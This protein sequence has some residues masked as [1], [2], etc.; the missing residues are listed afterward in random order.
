MS[1]NKITTDRILENIYGVTASGTLTNNF[2]GGKLH[3]VQQYQSNFRNR[4]DI[5]NNMNNI[6]YIGQNVVQKQITGGV[7]RRKNIRRKANE[8]SKDNVVI[9]ASPEYVKD[10]SLQIFMDKFFLYYRMS[11]SP[12]SAIYIIP[13]D[14]TLKSMISKRGDGKEGSIELQSSVRQ[15]KE[16]QW[17]KYFFITFGDNSKSDRYRI[18]PGLTDISAYPNKSFDE[19][20][21]TNLLGEVFYISYKDKDTV[22]INSKPNQHD[23]NQL[24][25]IARFNNGG[26]IFKGDIPK[27]SIEK[28]GPKSPTKKLSR[29]SRQRFDDLSFGDIPFVGGNNKT[30]FDVLQKYDEAYNFD[31][32]LASEHFIR[33]VANKI[34]DKK[35]FSNSDML[36]NSLYYCATNPQGVNMSD[37]GKEMNE[38]DFKQL[39]KDY[40]PLTNTNFEQ[41]NNLSKKINKLYINNVSDKNETRQFVNAVKNIYKNISDKTIPTVDILTGY[42]REHERVNYNDVYNDIYDVLSNDETATC[43]TCSLINNSMTANMLPSLVGRSALPV[44]CSFCG[45]SFESSMKNVSSMDKQDSE[46]KQNIVK[47]I[48]QIKQDECPCS[49]KEQPKQIEQPQKEPE[50]V[51]QQEPNIAADIYDNH[52]EEHD[53]EVMTDDDD[54]DD[55]V[56]NFFGE[57]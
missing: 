7:K 5:I 12:N 25:F 42:T 27:E 3:Y 46:E 29:Q 32:E 34:T 31:H 33:C 40:K 4:Q 48:F 24:K 30:S 49:G 14:T 51:E 43:Q 41:I 55:L 47:D 35:Y 52:A 17:E 57:D 11:R 18:D 1:T 10:S 45:G 22:Y 26:Y 44:F 15:N 56:E 36:F 20:R 16:I 23:G 50:P 53:D 19:V 21:R 6:K 2:T 39:F 13:S 38:N 28:I 9:Y 37:F 54:I 8:K